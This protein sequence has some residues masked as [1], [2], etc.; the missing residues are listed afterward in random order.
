MVLVFA[1]IFV[2]LLFTAHDIALLVGVIFPAPFFVAFLL[3]ILLTVLLVK[4]L[5]VVT[6]LAL[7]SLVAFFLV[8][9]F[10][11]SMWCLSL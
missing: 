1:A 6:V 11:R 2:V 10:W 8:L 9:L 4:I 7:L 5:I 3:A